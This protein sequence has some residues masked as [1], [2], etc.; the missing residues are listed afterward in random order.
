MNVDAFPALKPAESEP[1][2]VQLLLHGFEFLTLDLMPVLELL[3]CLQK[4]LL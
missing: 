3:E 4:I 2:R 1:Q